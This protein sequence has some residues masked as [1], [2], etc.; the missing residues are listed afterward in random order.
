MKNARE[1]ERRM[2]FT[3]R[4][5]RRRAPGIKRRCG[6]Q[7]NAPA[8]SAAIPERCRLVHALGAELALALLLFAVL[9]MGAAITGA[10]ARTPQ[11][12][13]V[14]SAARPTKTPPP[15]HSPTPTTVP[16]PTPAPAPSPT[17]TAP[18]T[19]IATVQARATPPV[20]ATPPSVGRQAGGSQRRPHSTLPT[21]NPAVQQ[22]SRVQQQGEG[23]FS[24]LVLG[25]LSGIAAVALLVAVG[26]WLLRKWLLPVM[27]VKVPPSGATPWERV[28]P[29]S[30][31]KSQDSAGYNRQQLPTT[32]AFIPAA[33]IT[34]PSRPSTASKGMPKWQARPSTRHLLRPTRLKA[35]HT[36]GTPAAVKSSSSIP[37][38]QNGQ[39]MAPMR[40][41]ESAKD[42]E[43]ML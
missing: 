18:P 24:P 5:W 10:A 39:P 36:S 38:R 4:Q 25:I 21:S 31:Q 8:P 35:I 34:V 2:G 19:T 28:R 32:D 12:L 17:L 42:A 11:Q 20:K 16:S 37:P 40:E 7:H 23:A 14:S 33:R 26:R 9:G 1:P 22:P 41:R 3:L 30:L 15:R 6:R 43:E 27:K 29:T 13:S